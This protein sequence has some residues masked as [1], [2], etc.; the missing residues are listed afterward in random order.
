M[1]L[2]GRQN[3]LWREYV[4]HSTYDDYWKAISAREKF[5][6]V[7]I[8]VFMMAGWYDY[9][10]GAAFSAF[11]KLRGL[12]IESDVRIVVN[13]ANHYNLIVGDRDFGDGPHKDELHLAVRWLDHVVKGESNGVEHEPP[14][15][16][17]VMGTNEWRGE[18]EWPPAGAL[19]TEYYFQSD[20]SRVG[21]LSTEPPGDEPPSQ[22]RYDPEDPAPTLGGN[23]SSPEDDPE[24]IRVGPVDQRPLADRADVLVFTSPPL[25][26]DLEVTGPV[27]VKLWASTTGRDTDFIARLIDVSED[28]T[29]YNLTEGIIRARFRQ[30]IWEEPSLL[31]PGDVYEY[32]LELLPTSNV[33]LRGHRIC[34]HLTSSSFPMFDRNPNTGNEQGM[35]AELMAVDQ[36]I[37]HDSLRPSHIVL[38]V[39]YPKASDLTTI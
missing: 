21:K 26:E 5:D 32:S 24:I 39:S 38:P 20:G 1:A 29:A 7:T 28:G 16:I 14:V 4:S 8:P 3:R 10:T 2:T 37:Y 11:Q 12:D 35:D 31:T 23:H 27:V 18:Y 6:R 36:T 30:S 34:V 9:Y 22:Y 33:F 15:S 13:P 17:F 19:S 25:D